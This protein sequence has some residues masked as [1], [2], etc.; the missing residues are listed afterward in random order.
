M[1]GLYGEF[2]VRWFDIV[3]LQ[4]LPQ[5]T[6]GRDPGENQIPTTITGSPAILQQKYLAPIPFSD[7]ILEPGWTQNAGY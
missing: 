2:G 6:A 7:M 5:I 1:L 4:M 3:R